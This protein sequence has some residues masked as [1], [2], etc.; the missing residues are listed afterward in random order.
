MNP[1][2]PP[3]NPW[4]LLAKG[5]DGREVEAGR[6]STTAQAIQ[7]VEDYGVTDWRLVQKATTQQTTT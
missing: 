7:F 6:F 4:I 1:Q 5:P 2:T 3:T